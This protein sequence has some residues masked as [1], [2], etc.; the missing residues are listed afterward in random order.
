[1]SSKLNNFIVAAFLFSM[2]CFKI[3]QHQKLDYI[4]EQQYALIFEKWL[5]FPQ[6]PF[7][8]K[9]NSS[10]GSKIIAGRQ[11]DSWGR[12]D[13][14]NWPTK[15][16]RLPQR[17]DRLL[18]AELPEQTFQFPFPPPRWVMKGCGRREDGV[19]FHTF[20][21][22]LFPHAE[23]H[24][25]LDPLRGK[26]KGKEREK[27]PRSVRP[28]LSAT[29]FGFRMN[30]PALQWKETLFSALLG[31]DAATA[32]FITYCHTHDGFNRQD[33]VFETYLMCLIELSK[34]VWIT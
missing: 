23:K 19:G 1:M 15:Q 17:V 12:E 18:S 28:H 3:A 9:Y 22:S 26:K 16:L 21:F 25:E 11:R 20:L 30:G 14:I 31:V 24:G 32:G 2:S 27:A 13:Q 8:C 10:H 4:K 7:S 33:S 34:P 29:M 5:I 6:L